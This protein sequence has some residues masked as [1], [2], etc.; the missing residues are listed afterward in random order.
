MTVNQAKESVGMPANLGDTG[1]GGGQN[2]AGKSIVCT[3]MY[4]T[5]GLEDWSKAMKIWYIY[6]KKY[7]TI[8]HQ[9]G[10]HKLFKPFVKGMHKNKI[11]R[12]IGAHVAKHRTQDLKHIMFGSKSSWLGRVYRKILEPICYIVGK[13]V[14]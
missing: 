12:I 5:T 7:L 1:G 6:Q 14:K 8:Q 13:Y 4:Q 3:A 11:I 9:E 10:Y 2:N